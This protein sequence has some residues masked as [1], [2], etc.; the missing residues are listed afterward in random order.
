[1]A[2]EPGKETDAETITR[3]A[4]LSLLEYSRIRKGEAERLGVRVTDLDA[5]VKRARE[6]ARVDL[7]AAG[8]RGRGRG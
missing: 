8:R 7:S 1:V 3:L 4:A 6:G 5:E 2:T